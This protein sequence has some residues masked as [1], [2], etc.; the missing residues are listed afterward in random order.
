MWGEMRF[1][2]YQTCQRTICRLRRWTGRQTHDVQ[3]AIRER[4]CL[5][6]AAVRL[7]VVGMW[8]LLSAV[9]CQW[10]VMAALQAWLS[11]IAPKPDAAALAFPAMQPWG[12]RAGTATT[13]LGGLIL[14]PTSS[15]V[16][17]VRLFVGICC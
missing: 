5:C 7:S 6:R 8:C 11:C 9:S 14:R 17:R 13:P 16:L 4:T 1:A 2:F 15:L 12:T 10:T 3:P